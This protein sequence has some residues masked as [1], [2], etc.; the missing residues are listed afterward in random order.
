MYPVSPRH[1]SSPSVA[2]LLITAAVCLALG[3]G[4]ARHGHTSIS[5]MWRSPRPNF[6]ANVADWLMV[7]RFMSYDR[8]E[9]EANLDAKVTANASDVSL[10]HSTDGDAG[11]VSLSETNSSSFFGLDLGLS[12]SATADAPA[13]DPF[14]NNS[15]LASSEIE[16]A[17]SKVELLSAPGEDA[18]SPID[19]VVEGPAPARERHLLASGVDDPAMDRLRDM[20]AEDETSPNIE[21]KETTSAD[22][23]A[24]GERESRLIR[25]RVDSLLATAQ[26]KLERGQLDDARRLGRQ[27]LAMAR[28][29]PIPMQYRI[30][31]AKWLAEIDNRQT[32][33]AIAKVEILPPSPADAD[34]PIPIGKPRDIG[35]FAKDDALSRREPSAPN[36]EQEMQPKPQA[37]NPASPREAP[38]KYSRQPVAPVANSTEQWEVE[39]DEGA[40]ATVQNAA[41]ETDRKTLTAAG[42]NARLIANGSAHLLESQISPTSLSVPYDPQPTE[43]AAAPAFLPPE[44]TRWDTDEELVDETSSATAVEAE[45]TA[46]TTGEVTHLGDIAWE[47]EP[48]ERTAASG[49]DAQWKLLIGLICLLIGLSAASLLRH[50]RRNVPIAMPV[51]APQ[52][53]PRVE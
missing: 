11:H 15:A 7:D 13:H 18:E 41:T 10:A 27:A 12:R 52:L 50:S 33:A 5:W 20:L 14:L 8:N 42:S 29:S 37:D 36:L 3:S 16:T 48:V 51:D 19:S 32:D 28:S 22:D 43:P 26:D 30:S 47:D 46:A 53:E 2:P 45:T 25:Q 17:Q 4:C 49:D 23:A 31:P 24:P 1:K 34:V 38:R 39:A 21:L 35:A 6:S 40:L 44:L 9:A